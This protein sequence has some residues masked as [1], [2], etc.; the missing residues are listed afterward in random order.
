MEAGHIDPNQALDPG[1]IY[2][3]SPEDYVNLPCLMNFDE[4]QILKITGSNSY[5][6]SNPSRDLIYPS[7][8]ILYRIKEA[9]LFRKFQRNVTNVG[10]DV[11]TY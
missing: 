9:S 4:E 5:N 7:F 2:D 6:C 11:V 10:Q 1:L 8:M 3:A